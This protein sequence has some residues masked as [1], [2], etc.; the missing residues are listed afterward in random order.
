VRSRPDGG[1]PIVTDDRPYF[2]PERETMPRAQRAEASLA[3]LKVQLQRSYAR[4]PFYRRIWDAHG[5]HP[6]QVRT[7]DDFTARCPTIT[8]KLLVA[9][10]VEHPPF[11]SYLGIE[12][13]EIV[14]VH[15]STGTSGTPTLYGVGRE[16]W[17]RA[18]HVFAITQWAMGVRPS[19]VVQFA[20]PF[21]IFF[22]GWGVLYGAEKIGAA[23]FPI[24]FADTQRHVQLL[25]RLGST[26]IEATPSYLLH[27][28]EVAEE[29]G[30]DPAASPLRRAIVGGE[31]GGSIPSTRARIMER[32]GLESV[33][34]SGST[35]EMFPF[36]TNTECTEMAG[37]HL[38]LD[39]VWTEVVDPADHSRPLPE[40][41]RG[42]VIYTHLWRTSQPMIRFAP[43]DATIMTSEPCACGRTYPRLPGGIL[44]RLDDMLVVRGVNVYP[45]AIE[46]ALRE[47]EGLGLEFRVFVDRHE[48][49]DE[50]SVETEVADANTAV[51]H[52]ET[53]RAELRAR[54]A[55]ALRYHCQVRIDVTLVEPGTFERT[56]L[57]ARRVVDRRESAL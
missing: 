23:C 21:S 28:A 45:S 24:G 44:G 57:K 47:I 42:A 37:P 53:K 49:M 17:E 43:G 31:P 26:V 18:G 50:I 48:H 6:D 40:G 30:F 9:D 3:Q 14:R 39:E 52:D 27:M 41:E 1:D 56:T 20:F 38:W 13:S 51:L 34:D 11:G 4:I 22:G 55:E 36:C 29:L 5:F 10:Q 54:A 25:Y 7:W 15:G 46:H 2:D 35:S 33:C 12:R 8:K 19:D 16:D 32:W